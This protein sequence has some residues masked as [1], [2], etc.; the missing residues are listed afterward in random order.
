MDENLENTNFHHSAG[1]VIR[2]L[3][4]SPTRL[5]YRKST[6]VPMACVKTFNYFG[7][8][9]EEVPSI[10]LVLQLH[11]CTQTHTHTTHDRF[12]VGLE[13]IRECERD[14]ITDQTLMSGISPILSTATH[15]HTHCATYVF[16]TQW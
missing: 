6:F 2:T 12:G 14:N 4:S 1:I 16:R 5:S 10:P 3:C 15:T 11:A 9:H 8:A 7:L 13:E